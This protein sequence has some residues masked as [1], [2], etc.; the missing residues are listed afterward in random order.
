MIRFPIT[1]KRNIWIPENRNISGDLGEQVR[2][3]AQ[4]QKGLPFLDASVL[5]DF[6]SSYNKPQEQ[7][8]NHTHEQVGRKVLILA[9]NIAGEDLISSPDYILGEKS[10]NDCQ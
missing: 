1:T 4:I 10:K 2:G 5:D 9:E 8:H 7:G 3:P 6:F